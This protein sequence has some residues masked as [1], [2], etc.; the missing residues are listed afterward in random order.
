MFNKRLRSVRKNR[1]I[2]V[3]CMADHLNLSLRAYQFYESGHRSP[4]LDTL[5]KIA[6]FLDVSID[7][8]ACRDDFLKSHGINFD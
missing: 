4:P 2:K 7:Y 1:G 3:Q 8:L 5:I 6:N